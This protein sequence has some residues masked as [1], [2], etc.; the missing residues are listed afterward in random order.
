M[1]YINTLNLQQ[2]II[3]FAPKM[4]RMEQFQESLCKHIWFNARTCI[5][6]KQKQFRNNL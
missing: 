6:S 2:K 3:Y 4:K 5:Y 1:V